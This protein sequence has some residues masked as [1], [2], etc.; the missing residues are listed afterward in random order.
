[1]HVGV[2]CVREARVQSLQ[3]DLDNLETSY[4]ESI[5]NFAEKFTTLSVSSEMRWRRSM[6]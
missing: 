3:A 6:L 5:D 1:M 4:A 2:E